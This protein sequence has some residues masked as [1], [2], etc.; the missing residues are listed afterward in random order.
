[1]GEKCCTKKEEC[2]SSPKCVKQ[3]IDI[4]QLIAYVVSFNLLIV[5]FRLVLLKKEETATIGSGAWT[6]LWWYTKFV[7]FLELQLFA[8]YCWYLMTVQ[9]Y[10][11]LVSCLKNLYRFLVDFLGVVIPNPFM[12]WLGLS[13]TY[14]YLYKI[15][16]IF[17]ILYYTLGVFVILGGYLFVVLLFG[18]YLLGYYK[19]NSS[20]A[21]GLDK[22]LK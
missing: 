20:K 15:Y 10:N 22:F 14:W 16:C 17:G 3:G 8:L 6:V 18:P 5:I 11:N 1:M 13:K 21:G 19:I 4:K 9:T 12:D 2:D 7:F